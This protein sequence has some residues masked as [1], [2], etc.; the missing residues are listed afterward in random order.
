MNTKLDI[1]VYVRYG[2]LAKYKETINNFDV[3]VKDKYG[4]TLLHEAIAHRQYEIAFDLLDRNI[5]V[6]VQ[7][8]KGQIAL[9]YIPF[10][11]KNFNPVLAEKIIQKTE[12]I[13]KKDSHGNTTLWYAIQFS[14]GNYSLVQLLKKYGANPLALNN[15]GKTPFDV[16]LRIGDQNLIE[17]ID[18]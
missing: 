15:V 4:Y 7:D 13:D 3:N 1:F 18:E 12:D 11:M 2:K 5:D 6:N 14:K 17:M 9:H 16:A 10:Y 8:S